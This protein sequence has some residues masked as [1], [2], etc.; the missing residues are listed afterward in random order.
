MQ[1]PGGLLQ[2][3]G[4]KKKKKGPQVILQLCPWLQLWPICRWLTHLQIQPKPFTRT[5]GLCINF[6]CAISSWVAQMYLRLNMC[7]TEPHNLLSKP[8]LLLKLSIPVNSG[9][10]PKSNQSP[11]A[12]ILLTFNS[13]LPTIT[14]YNHFSWVSA[15]TSYVIYHIQPF[16][17][18]L[19]E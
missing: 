1:A 12:T 6:V 8:D 16:S 7:K 4:F 14:H 3:S 19:P 10:S 13:I 5:P 11:S 18:W 17:R 15:I 9:S 2:P